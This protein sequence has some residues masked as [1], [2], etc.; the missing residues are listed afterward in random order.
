MGNNFRNETGRF[1]SK[2]PEHDYVIHGNMDAEALLK[3]LSKS[4]NRE[5]LLRDSLSEIEQELRKETHYQNK[6]ISAIYNRLYKDNQR[7]EAEKKIVIQNTGNV[8]ISDKA[9]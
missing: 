6:L 7:L 4:Q 2:T 1:A 5:G 3:E 9:A 8:Y